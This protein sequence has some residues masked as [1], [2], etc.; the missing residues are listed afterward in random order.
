MPKGLLELT[1]TID[2]AQFWPSGESD[3]DTVKVVRSGPNA[4]R[5]TPH[6]GAQT[7][8]THAF[9]GATVKGKISKL[10]IDDKDRVTIRLQGIDAPE[11]HYRPTAPT[12]NGKKPSTEQRAKFKA[13]N[14]NFRQHFGETATVAL[15]SFLAKAGKSPLKCVVRT[16]VDEPNDVFDTFGRL[17]GDIFVTINGAEQNV[18]HWL[19]QQGW[20]F[21]TFYSSM[22]NSEIDELVALSESG[23]KAKRGIWRTASM[24]LA[25][26]DKTLLFRNKGTPDPVNDSGP[27]FLPKLFR[28]R[29]TFGVA[30]TAKM[31]SG[32][33][34][35]YLKMEPDACFETSDFLSQGVTAATP[36]HLDEFVSPN[37]KFLVGAGDLVFQENKSQVVD[38]KGNSV[39][40]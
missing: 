17:I 36:R 31:T 5:F 1:G 3:A 18:N 8:V 32:F 13:A 24:D 25:V 33:F 4:F 2:L 26:F 35:N 6:P 14:G 22:T 20:A 12:L 16:A 19:C 15:G 27:V 23:R 7:K 37:S 21:P 29:S 39:K 28:R 11:L 40:W 38:K 10:A 30:M 34:K 9:E